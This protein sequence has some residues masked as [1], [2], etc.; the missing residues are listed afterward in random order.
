MTCMTLSTYK[1]QYADYGGTAAPA[2]LYIEG[3]HPR[4]SYST[5]AV[6]VTSAAGASR[7]GS[8]HEGHHVVLEAQQLQVTS[9]PVVVFWRS[10]AAPG[11]E[12]EGVT[13][14]LLLSGTSLPWGRAN[15]SKYAPPL[16]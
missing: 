15:P 8:V 12:E 9:P 10:D 13:H 4:C 2:W 11:A 3:A 7:L 5:L 6:F 16:F 14:E 1:L